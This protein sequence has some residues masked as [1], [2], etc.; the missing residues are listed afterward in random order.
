LSRAG[1]KYVKTMTV[2]TTGSASAMQTAQDWFEARF[3]EG[4]TKN[5]NTIAVFLTL[6]YIHEE[7]GTQ[8][9]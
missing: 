4:T 3:A 9:R 1:R 8:L 2:S 6:A 5:I 7:E